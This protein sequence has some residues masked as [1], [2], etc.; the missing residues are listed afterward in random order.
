MTTA[1]VGAGSMIPVGTLF[2]DLEPELAST[3]RLLERYPDEH[4]D[5][6]P[7]EKSM[8]LSELAGHVAELAAFGAA[9]ASQPGWDV[10]ANKYQR[11]P[12][13]TRD[14]MLALFDRTA[15]MIREA[16]AG[17][18][19]AALDHVWKIHAG[20]TV[21]VQGKRAPLLRQLF[22]SHL[23]HHRGQLTVYYRILGVAVPGMYGPTADEQ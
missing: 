13:R 16:L 14:E 23:A 15:P 20:D 21:F 6:K 8:S 9:V 18:D 2:L 7:H 10:T 4:A 3:R 11:T 5:W 19:A 12:A 17:L 1:S 22:F